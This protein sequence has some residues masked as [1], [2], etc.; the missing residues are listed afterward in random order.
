RLPW[1]RGPDRDSVPASLEWEFR[2]R[3]QQS[4]RAAAHQMHQRLGQRFLE[5]GA[6][7]ATSSRLLQDTTLVSAM[8]LSSPGLGKRPTTR[9][10]SIPPADADVMSP[11]AQCSVS[12]L[13]LPL[14][15]NST[16]CFSREGRTGRVA[17]RLLY[18][19]TAQIPASETE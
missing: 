19:K 9:R 3:A 15:A 4:R 13:F 17:S 6:G 8:T 1:P 14:V 2:M 18:A 7:L 16:S 10:I 11:A 5:I 12:G